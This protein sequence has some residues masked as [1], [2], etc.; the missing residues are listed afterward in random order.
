[1]LGIMLIILAFSSLKSAQNSVLVGENGT[2]SAKK[3]GAK[4]RLKKTAFAM[5]KK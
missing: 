4:K 3:R 2:E 1:M 5:K